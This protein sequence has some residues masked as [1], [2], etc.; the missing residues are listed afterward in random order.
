MNLIYETQ[1]LRVF[2]ISNSLPLKEENNLLECIIELFTPSVVL[3]LPS[4]FHK[5]KS[6]ADAKTWFDRMNSESSLFV[7][8]HNESNKIMGFIFAFVE[9]ERD[10]HIGYLLGESYWKQGYASEVLK[11]FLLNAKKQKKW[12]KLIAGVDSNNEVSS[13][14]LLKT[15]F[16]TL[17]T[18]DNYD[19]QTK[20]YEYK[21]CL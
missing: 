17:L 11:G 2:E 13:K 21:L 16:I 20:F 14:L 10:A 3:N 19:K 9:N 4:Y 8:K 5:I 15:G 6:L 1:R 7:I 18:D 12:N